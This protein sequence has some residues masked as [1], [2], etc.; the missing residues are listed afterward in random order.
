VNWNIPSLPQPSKHET[1]KQTNHEP[2]SL[3]SLVQNLVK[4][5]EVEASFKPV[6][7]DWR[8]VD[9]ANY[10]FAINGSE[11]QGA[12]HMLKVRGSLPNSLLQDTT[13]N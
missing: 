7:S 2:G 13:L 3:P 12:E 10:T 1:A 8:T 4:N 9:H 11:P 5:W 6:L